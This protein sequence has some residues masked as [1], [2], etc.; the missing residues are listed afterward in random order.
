MIEKQTEGLVLQARR[1]D[2]VLEKEECGGG[3]VESIVP[4]KLRTE[5]VQRCFQLKS[6]HEITQPVAL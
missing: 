4:L 6:R 3:V 2:H 5:L 1:A